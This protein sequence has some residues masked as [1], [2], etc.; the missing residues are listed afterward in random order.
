MKTQY[1]AVQAEQPKRPASAGLAGARGST[2]EST[3]FAASGLQSFGG[4]QGRLSSNKN[5]TKRNEAGLS[6]SEPEVQ[7]SSI[8]QY[9]DMF[10]EKHP[11]VF[12]PSDTWAMLCSSQTWLSKH[13]LSATGLTEV[14]V[15]IVFSDGR[16]MWSASRRKA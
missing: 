14:H 10:D 12:K 1:R 6:R 7:V 4:P 8:Q 2:K 11:P 16:A 5:G 15:P 9:R 3:T 13:G